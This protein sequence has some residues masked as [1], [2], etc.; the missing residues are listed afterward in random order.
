MLCYGCVVEK[1]PIKKIK[2]SARE[3]ISVYSPHVEWIG[4]N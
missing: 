1:G 4:L 3:A 2:M